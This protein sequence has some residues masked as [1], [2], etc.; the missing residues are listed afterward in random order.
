IAPRA[1]VAAA[2]AVGAKGAAGHIQGWGAGE[3]GDVI[4]RAAVA[5]ATIAAQVATGPSD[6]DAIAP[7][8]SLRG[9]LAERISREGEAGLRGI[10]GSEPD[11]AALAHFAV[12]ACGQ[13]GGSDAVGPGAA[14]GRIADESAVADSKHQSGR[15]LSVNIDSA[16][17]PGFG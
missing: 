5:L 10:V 12:A 16:P 8:A 13:A 1:A 17:L 7:C 4:E 11:R 3:T 6:G 15:K 9:A 14:R 2:T